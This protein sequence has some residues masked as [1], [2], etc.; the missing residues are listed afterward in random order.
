MRGSGFKGMNKML[1]AA[2]LAG[3]VVVSAE[4]P[5]ETRLPKKTNQDSP[6]IEFKKDPQQTQLEPTTQIITND[7]RGA[8][9]RGQG[10]AGSVDEDLRRRI[11]VSLSTGSLGTQGVL[12]S[13]QLT[14]I[15]V[16]VTN[17]VVTL[18]GEVVS[19][20]NREVIGKRV[21]GLDGVKGV[22]N[23]LKVNPRAKPARSDLFKPDGYSSGKQTVPSQA[24]EK[25]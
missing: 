1:I 6:P 14:D 2:F 16:A 9:P 23:Q 13:N 19:E 17:R 5:T 25:Q 21:A 20:K 22:N 4:E 24:G 3:G 12:A 11:L 15:K 10:D 8:A 7:A 18:D